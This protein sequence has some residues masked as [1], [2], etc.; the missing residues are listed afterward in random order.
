MAGAWRE[1]G[2]VD[3]RRRRD[4]HRGQ[5]SS[6]HVRATLIE[7][8][9]LAT[10]DTQVANSSWLLQQ[11]VLQRLR[12]VIALDG[13]RSSQVRD[14]PRDLE[15]AVVPTRAQTETIDCAAE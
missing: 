6:G 3:A 9:E 12:H 7:F 2:P 13:F 10:K 1:S 8:S 15:D 14:R 4:R 5:C 11:P